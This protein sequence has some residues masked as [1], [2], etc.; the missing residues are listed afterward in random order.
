M[1]LGL[2]VVVPTRH[3]GGPTVVVGIRGVNRPSGASG[4]VQRYPGETIMVAHGASAP[5]RDCIQGRM[6]ICMHG[7]SV[8]ID[9]D[10]HA[11]LKRIAAVEHVSVGEAVRRAVRRYRQS[12]MG[13]QLAVDPSEDER[14]WLEADFR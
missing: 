7:T 9:S 12:S 3:S 5:R 2:A 6:L 1:G 14:A 11:A 10:T 4:Q 13:A 8:R